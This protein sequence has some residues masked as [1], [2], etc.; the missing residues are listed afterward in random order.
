[1]QNVQ[2]FQ[3]VH[4]NNH[5]VSLLQ[6]GDFENAI[7]FFSAAFKSSKDALHQPSCCDS[8]DTQPF[9]SLDDCIREG[10]IPC[11]PACSVK[12][13]TM[14]TEDFIV[15]TSIFIPHSLQFPA[16]R[17]KIR[18]TTIVVFNL[19]LSFHLRAMETKNQSSRTHHLQRAAQLYEQAYNLQWTHGTG[20]LATTN[21]FSMAA[22]N[23]LGQVFRCLCEDEKAGHCFAH[24]LSTLLF[25]V[26]HRNAENR[27]K[28]SFE[29]IPGFF[30]TTSYLLS[31]DDRNK[32]TAAA[33][34]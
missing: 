17:C 23:N 25:M 26:D 9:T 1:M 7:A 3:T 21:L 10:P 31:R 33:A 14:E 32:N 19:A 11:D 28:E 12:K 29:Y 24:L 15:R 13:G 18:V 2:H 20:V 5:A 34:A 8:V 30:R 6:T 16:Y 22:L 4:L 27:R